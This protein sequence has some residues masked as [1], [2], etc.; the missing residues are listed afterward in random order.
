MAGMTRT[1]AKW[2]TAM[3][4]ALLLAACGGT[5]G[6]GG[7]SSSSSRDDARNGDYELYAADARQYTLRLD[8]DRRTWRM[9]GTGVDESGTFASESGGFVFQPVTTGTTATTNNARFQQQS[10]AVIG[11]FRFSSGLLPFVA[12]R[13]FVTS[14]A[15]AAGA[16]NFVTR[17]VDSAAA[18][19]TA[20]FSGEITTGGQLRTCGD[21]TIHAIANCPSASV[22]TGTL[23]VSGTEF[24]AQTS[25][26][27]FP[28]RIARLGTDR[29]LLRASVS[30][31]TTSRF[32]VGTPATGAFANGSF[33][34]TNSD[35]AAGTL[36]F[37][38]A[39]HSATLQSAA[40]ASSTRSGTTTPVGD[41]ATGLASLLRLDTT[42]SGP[43][44]FAVRNSVLAALVASRDST[45]AP[46]FVEIGRVP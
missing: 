43:S 23:T 22:T 41:S 10:D 21:T 35:G 14:I 13:S 18:A 45:V 1:W 42:T 27:N 19:N 5:D 3:C 26:G 34:V 17:T 37:T 29:V 15:E 9:R 6:S 44:F 46:G 30:T 11:A 31:G 8:F 38:A 32:W 24:T 12:S 2:A 20:I 16:Y 36:T 28:F 40:G 39:A 25:G 4:A 7:S 33:S